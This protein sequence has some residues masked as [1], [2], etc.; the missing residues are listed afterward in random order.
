MALFEVTEFDRRFYA[1]KLRDRLPDRLLDVH[2]HVYLKEHKNVRGGVKSRAVSW[3]G[4]VAPDDSV[5]DLLET[6]RIMFPDKHVTPNIFGSANQTDDL[7]A[8]N[9][10]IAE[11]AAKYHLPAFLYA[12]PWWTRA[13]LESRLDGYPFKGLKV[14]LQLSPAYIPEKEIRIFDFLTPKMLDVVN[15]RKLA[16]MLHIPR[17]GRLKDPVNIEQIREIC[18][19]WPEVKLII[20]HIGRAYCRSDVGEGLEILKKEPDL[21][22]D[23]SANCNTWVMEQLIR[24]VGPERILFGSDMPIL[25]MRTR[26]IEEDGRYVNLVAPGMYGDVSNDSHMREVAGE[27]FTFFMYREL[28]AFLD[29]A[30]RTGLSRTDLE[31]VF[32]NNAARV[33]EL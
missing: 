24:A 32:W 18:H 12:P 29:A 22:F 3:P 15:E 7:D 21:L 19:G 23:F 4:L 33:L 17:D 13:E 2:T 16:V 6:Y 9:R 1:E 11:S 20:A 28:E 8:Q 27:E 31:D 5:E 25:R 14:Y 30:D 10:Y 26:R